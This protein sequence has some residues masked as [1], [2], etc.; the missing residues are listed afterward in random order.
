MLLRGEVYGTG[1]GR[2]KKAAE[3]A[4]A[5]EAWERLQR[6]RDRAPRDRGDRTAM[7]ELPEVE[8][9]R[10]DLEREV[11]GKKIKSVEADGMRAVRRHH[12]RKQFA[13]RLVGKK[14]VG[15]ERRGQVPAAAGSTATTCS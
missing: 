10:R 4:A 14:I 1:E 9:V 8:V 13:N 5:R 6:E 7:P 2:S 3:Q 11:V 15:V 12:N